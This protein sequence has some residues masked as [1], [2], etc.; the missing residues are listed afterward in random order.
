[1]M[2]SEATRHVQA[3]PVDATAPP[4]ASPSLPTTTTAAASLEA[5]SSSAIAFPSSLATTFGDTLMV[6]AASFPFDEQMMAMPA[7]LADPAAAAAAAAAIGA[8]FFIDTAAIA[9]QIAMA[10][11]DEKKLSDVRIRRFIMGEFI[12]MAHGRFVF[13]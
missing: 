6:D 2:V 7:E 8:S 13:C 9:Q 3:P 11:T 10:V 4:A 1:M 5:T 12:L